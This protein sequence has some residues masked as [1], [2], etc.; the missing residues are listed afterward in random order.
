MFEFE[1]MC[2]AFEE[3]SNGERKLY[4]QEQSV[5]LINAFDKF[6]SDGI[7]MF[8]YFMAVAC[9]ADGKLSIEEYSLLQEVSP[10]DLKY[11]E[12]QTLVNQFSSKQNKEKATWI[13]DII[14]QFSEEMQDTIISFCLC[15]CSADNK[16]NLR[17]RQFIKSL[18]K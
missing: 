10:V 2:K 17:E 7:Q 15:F 4:L 13:S 5:K 1:N 3:M 8:L 6:G 12:A 18:V 16:V 14:G 9:G 11:T